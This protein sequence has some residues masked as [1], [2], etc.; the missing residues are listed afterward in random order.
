MLARLSSREVVEIFKTPNVPEW[1]RFAQSFW[2]QFEP[3][4]L[5]ESDRRRCIDLMIGYC[6]RAFPVDRGVNMQEL[7]NM[8]VIAAVSV[9]RVRSGG[10]LVF[11]QEYAR[12]GGIPPAWFSPVENQ[13]M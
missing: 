8:V 3:S 1:L 2:S 7:R 4:E 9:E 5:D 12:R 10:E 13:E 11:F 6:Q